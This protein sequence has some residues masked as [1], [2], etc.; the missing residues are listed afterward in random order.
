MTN[1]E[2]F[3]QAYPKRN[4]KKVGRNECGIWFVKFKP[5]TDMV[6][7]MIAWL[8][9]DSRNRVKSK[10]FYASLPDPI[11]FLKRVMWEDDIEELKL[12]GKVSDVCRT[13][14]C[15]NKWVSGYLCTKCLRIERGY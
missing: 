3:W 1:F 12:K 9:I 11:R 7:R 6:S 14:G 5:S 2:R 4:G 15:D 13:E 10:D 8:E